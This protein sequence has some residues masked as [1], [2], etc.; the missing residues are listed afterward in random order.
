MPLTRQQNLR[1]VLAGQTPAW[2]PFAPNFAQ[3]FHHHQK[4]ASLPP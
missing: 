2:V 1:L 3:W 4:F